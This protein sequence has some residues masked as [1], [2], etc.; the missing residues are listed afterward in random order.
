MFQ[1]FLKFGESNERRCDNEKALRKRNCSDVFN[2]DSVKDTRRDDDLS[3]D[4]DN[5]VQLRPQNLYLKLRVGELFYHC[6]SH[7]A[8]MHLTFYIVFMDSKVIN[9]YNTANL[10]C[11]V[12][13]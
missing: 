9:I 10:K 13:V 6:Y 3:S 2:R 12:A 1:D 4:P 7:Q 5:I 11:Y 8:T